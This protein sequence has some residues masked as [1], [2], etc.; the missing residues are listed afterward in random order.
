VVTFLLDAP[1]LIASADS[2]HVHHQA[3]VD[4]LGRGHR[5]ATSPVVEGALVRYLVRE[6]VTRDAAQA[7]LA[8][9]AAHPHHEFW[10]DALPYAQADLSQ[11]WGHRQVTDAYLVSLVRHHGPDARLATMD[12]AL[13]H[14]Y[15]DVV[16]LVGPA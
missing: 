13:A 5:F 16:T 12:R 14:T 1:V 7:A 9:I 8:A 6:G 4:W 11:V 15:P 3:A 2:E 10:P